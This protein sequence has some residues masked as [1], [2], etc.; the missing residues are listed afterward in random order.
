MTSDQ[1]GFAL[2]ETSIGTGAVAWQ[3]PALIGVQLPEATA[4]ATRARMQ[5]RFPA[6]RELP[7]PAMVQAAIT[8]IQQTLLGHSDDLIDLPLDMSAVP[9]FHQRVY[10]LV[11]AIPFGQTLTYGEVARRLGDAGAARAVGQAMGH[12][13]FAPVVPCH[14]VM[15]A[16]GKMGGFSAT[17]GAVTKRKML[18]TEGGLRGDTLDLF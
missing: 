8:R 9:P 14:R 2:F 16:Q 12:N 3:G 4:P 1:T 18:I 11:R 7:A 10:E 5:R 17:G 15:A 13:P 6:L